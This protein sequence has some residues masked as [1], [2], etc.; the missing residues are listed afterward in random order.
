MLG[1][2]EQVGGDERRV[3]VAVGEHED[4]ARSG[5]AVDVDEAEDLAL[6]GGDVGVA[7]ADDLVDARDLGGAEGHG[8]DRLGAA[9]GEHAVDAREL[10]GAQHHLGG[11][12]G[13][14]DHLAHAGDFGGDRR[15]QHRGW[16]RRGAAGGIHGDPR[17]RTGAARQLDRLAVQAGVGDALGLVEGADVGG[18]QRERLAQLGRHLRGGG[19]AMLTRELEL[20]EIAAL[21]AGREG[22]DGRVAVFADGGDDLAGGAV[23]FTLEAG[24]ASTQAL[25][26][27]VVGAVEVGAAKVEDLEDRGAVTAGGEHGCDRT[28]STPAGGSETGG[29]IR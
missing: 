11:A 6:G 27:G 19:G 25:P 21:M 14:Q 9:D 3:G 18:R 1:L 8:G 16:V 7:G 20:M 12:R 4:L 23:G 10:R 13:Q 24:G 28:A 15:H 26:R 5:D 29:E 17:E 2:G 22:A